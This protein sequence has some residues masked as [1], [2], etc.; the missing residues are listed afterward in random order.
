MLFYNLIYKLYLTTYIITY[1]LQLATIKITL[2]AYKKNI[3]TI[4]VYFS[5]PFF[6]NFF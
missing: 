1:N 3:V 6:L 2:D 5:N 4:C